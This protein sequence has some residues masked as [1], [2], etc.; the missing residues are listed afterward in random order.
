MAENPSEPIH[1]LLVEDNPADVRLTEEILREVKLPAYLTV[2]NH[3]EDALA[4]LR[5][6]GQYTRAP[7][8]DFI[9]L[10]LHLP[11]KNGYEVLAEIHSDPTLRTIPVAVCLGSEAEK[12]RLERYQLPV[13]CFFIKGFDPQQF[14][15][16]LTHCRAATNDA[17]S[18]CR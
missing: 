8:P 4:F 15:R 13:D 10:D 9:F 3:G 11:G 5:R 7:R 12:H 1:I 17:S 18:T 16:V 6:Q 14:L 2:V